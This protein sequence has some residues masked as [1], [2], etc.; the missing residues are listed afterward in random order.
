MFMILTIFHMLTIC[1]RRL[2]KHMGKIIENLHK[3]KY[4]MKIRLDPFTWF[5]N[6]VLLGPLCLLVMNYCTTLRVWSCYEGK[7]NYLTENMVANGEI[8]NCYIVFKDHLL[9]M[10]QKMHLYVGK[11][12]PILWYWPFLTATD[13]FWNH[14]AVQQISCVFP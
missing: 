1:C 9:H 8:A 10:H 2:W 5:Y 13:N 4:C 3:W 11:V 6:Y 14:Y 7:I 12:K